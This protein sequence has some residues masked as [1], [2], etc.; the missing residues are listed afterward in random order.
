MAFTNEMISS[1][2][3]IKYNFAGFD[4]KIFLANPQFDWAIDRARTIFL[5]VVRPEA[6]KIEPG[7]PDGRFEKDFHYHW[8]GY[9]YFVSTRRLD[10]REFLTFPGT[11][12][13]SCTSHEP[14][15]RV[16]RFYLRQISELRKPSDLSPSAILQNQEQLL[17]DLA[18]VLAYG[19]GGV[20][21]RLSPKQS[22]E[23]R[24]AI[25][26]IAPNALVQA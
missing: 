8:K 24:H 11:V 17:H 22:L 21:S 9:D 1:E 13:D 25:L 2:D 19:E 4:K 18:E 10:E 3:R 16:L 6:R 15:M 7:D 26:K 23:P 12:L 5:R 14:G 20:F